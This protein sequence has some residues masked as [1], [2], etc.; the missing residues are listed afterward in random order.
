[1]CW[2]KLERQCFSE[3]SFRTP[4]AKNVHSLA[5]SPAATTFEGRRSR[6][7]SSIFIIIIVIISIRPIIVIIITIISITL[8]LRTLRETAALRKW[9]LRVGCASECTFFAQG[10]RKL[11]SE[12]QCRSNSCQ[13]STRFYAK[14]A[15]QQSFPK[16]SKIHPKFVPKSTKNVSGGT[17]EH[18]RAPAKQQIDF[19]VDLF[20]KNDLTDT[21][22]FTNFGLKIRR[23][24][25]PKNTQNPSQIC[26]KIDEKHVRRHPGAPKSTS[27]AT[28]RLFCRSFCE[29]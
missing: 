7:A 25:D 21:M 10:V 20:A 22:I 27:E 14:N 8:L 29:K 4:W 24:C 23:K 12:K 13:H 9:L 6:A 11:S 5:R 28:D 18:P 17:R 15:P 26:P 2:Q 1:M 19:F 3:L 16:T